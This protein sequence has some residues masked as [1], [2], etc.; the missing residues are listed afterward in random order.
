MASPKPPAPDEVPETD[1]TYERSN[2]ET[3]LKREDARAEKRAGAKQSRPDP[4]PSDVPSEQQKNPP[5][6]IQNQHR[7]QQQQQEQQR[8][9]GRSAADRSGPLRSGSKIAGDMKTEEPD[10]WDQAPTDIKDPR[11]QRHPRPDGLGG[12]EPDSAR[13]DRK[14]NSDR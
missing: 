11:Q 6:R 13:R 8:A 2:A 4:V 12:S 1:A 3:T 10:G 9:G 7:R 5:V 14:R